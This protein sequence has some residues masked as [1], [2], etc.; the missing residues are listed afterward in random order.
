[1]KKKI[2]KTWYFWSKTF[3]VLGSAQCLTLNFVTAKNIPSVEATEQ[4]TT[5]ESLIC[6]GNTA[7]IYKLVSSSLSRTILH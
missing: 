5:T 7:T 6:L 4:L 3:Y 1:M 2:E